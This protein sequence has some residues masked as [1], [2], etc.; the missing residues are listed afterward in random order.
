MS[1]TLG[2]GGAVGLPLSGV[3][4]EAFGWQA[5]FW[6]SVAMSVVMLVLVLTVVP[7][8]GVRTPARF[9]WLGAVLLS[10]AL[11]ALLLGISKGGVWGWTSQWMLLSFLVAV[12]VFAMWAPWE[13]R[14]GQPLVDLRTSG[15]RPVLL[16]NIASLLAGF[17]MFT[18]LL[19]ATQQLQ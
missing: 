10:I 8:S 17:A 9:D 16:T 19:V 15:R 7:E 13:L 11:T 2:I 14:T 18:N 12:L 1:A 3:I 5:V 6:A 4:Y